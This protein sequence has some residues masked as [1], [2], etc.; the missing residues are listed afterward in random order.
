MIYIASPYTAGGADEAL[1]QE[2][3]EQACIATAKMTRNGHTV[4]SP[5][6]HSHPLTKCGVEGLGR[7]FAYWSKIDYEFIDLCD[8][9]VVLKLKGWQ[10]SKG[11]AEEVKYAESKGKIVN[12]VRPSQI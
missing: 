8:E 1:M 6:V 7:D 4:F 11:I 9:L 2:R 5:I 3:Y 10:D 12:Y